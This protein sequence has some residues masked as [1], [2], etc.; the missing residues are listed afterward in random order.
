M[1][2]DLSRVTFD[3]LK[4]YLRVVMQQGRVQVDA[5]LNEQTAILLHFLQTLAADLIGQHGGAEDLK[6]KVG[7]N[8]KI[9]RRNLGF[10]IITLESQLDRIKD[11]NESDHWKDVL[12]HQIDP[13]ILISKGRYY[14][15]GRLCEIEDYLPYSHQPGY[16]W[17]NEQ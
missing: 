7:N 15:N 9:I 16:P 17:L 13:P 10:E 1:N 12:V 4:H 3:P 8:E 5:D 2:G 11:T 14:V 6:V